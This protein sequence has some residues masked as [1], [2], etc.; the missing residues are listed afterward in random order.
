MQEKTERFKQKDKYDLTVINRLL[1]LEK[2]MSQSERHD[3]LASKLGVY[4]TRLSWFLRKK[5]D[6]NKKTK[7]YSAK[8][9]SKVVINY[10]LDKINEIVK[11]E[12][13]KGKK[14]RYH[15]IAKETGIN[16]ATLGHFFR[17]KCNHSVLIN[18]INIFEKYTLK[19]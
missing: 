9:S 13:I 6:Y 16:P 19:K 8:I 12:N 5:C 1:F 15:I 2:P 11:S 14:C 17:K 7:Y 18:E 3:F 4:K 10:D